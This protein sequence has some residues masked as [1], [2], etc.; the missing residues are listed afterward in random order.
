VIAG[1]RFLART[2]R[3]IAVFFGTDKQVDYRCSC[4]GGNARSIYA[5]RGH[6]GHTSHL[7]PDGYWSSPR[8]GVVAAGLSV[9]RLVVAAKERFRI[10]SA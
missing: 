9:D 6:G 1:R 4:M 7:K 5:L 10:P 8:I 2:V 3:L